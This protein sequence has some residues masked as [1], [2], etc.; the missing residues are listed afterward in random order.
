VHDL[1]CSSRAVYWGG[2]ASVVLGLSSWSLVSAQ[3]PDQDESPK[4]KD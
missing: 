2:W 1:Q 3:R 4:P